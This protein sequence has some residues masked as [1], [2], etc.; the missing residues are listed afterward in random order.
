MEGSRGDAGHATS[1]SPYVRSGYS[2]FFDRVVR[3]VVSRD[4][5]PKTLDLEVRWRIG[6]LG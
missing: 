1:Y 6:Y 3:V 5:D 4:D 2:R